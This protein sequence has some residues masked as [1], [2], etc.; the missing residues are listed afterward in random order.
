MES[1]FFGFPEPKNTE[2]K[3]PTILRHIYSSVV[4]IEE[5]NNLAKISKSIQLTVHTKNK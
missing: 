4:M 3:K 5:N 2:H 1:A